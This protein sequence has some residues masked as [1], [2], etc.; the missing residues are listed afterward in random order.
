MLVGFCEPTKSRTSM[1]LDQVALQNHKMASKH[2]SSSRRRAKEQ[3][4][5]AALAAYPAWRD[6]PVRPSQSQSCEIWMTE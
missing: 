1:V 2:A 6:T 5:Q 3:A 4:A